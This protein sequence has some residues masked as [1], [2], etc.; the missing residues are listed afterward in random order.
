MEECTPLGRFQH[1]VNKSSNHYILGDRFHNMVSPH[2][3]PLCLYHDVNLGNGS[4]TLKTSVQESQNYWKNARRLRSAGQ[5]QLE[6]HIAFNF[7]MDFHQNEEIVQRQLTNLEKGIRD[8]QKV[9]RN[10]WLRFVIM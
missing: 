4:N 9:T 5:Q 2:K 7:L 1:P 10:K 3:S 8:G 6:V